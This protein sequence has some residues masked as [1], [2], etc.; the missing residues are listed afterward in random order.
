MT[1]STIRTPVAASTGD[2]A[3]LNAPLFRSLTDR[4]A[5][6]RRRA[7]LDL[8]AATTPMLGLLGRSPCRV[9][10][11][12]LGSARELEQINAADP[13]AVVAT[14]DALLPARRDDSMFDAVFCWDI[15]NHLTRRGLTALMTAVAARAGPG[16]VAH[17]L[18]YYSARTMPARPGRFV[19]TAD[20]RLVDNAPAAGMTDAPRYSPEELDRLMVSRSTAPG[21]SRT[22][23]RSSCTACPAGTAQT[24][25]NFA[26]LAASTAAPCA[27]S[28]P[29]P[30]TASSWSAR[31][32]LTIPSSRPSSLASIAIE[33]TTPLRR[34][35]RVPLPGCR[36]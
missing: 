34:R 35:P 36:R 13:D 24:V 2:V 21:C 12:D 5:D 20:A 15:P 33:R 22:G 7:I 32:T 9:E 27:T 29:M 17:M 6:G 16:A 8:G 19:P 18:I 11:A 14:A 25:F 28:K 3:A 1:V 23:C 10:I 30:L 4:L 26:V 31:S